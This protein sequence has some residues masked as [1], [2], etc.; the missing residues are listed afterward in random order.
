MWLVHKHPSSLG[1]RSCLQKVVYILVIDRFEC[2]K[3]DIGTVVTRAVYV[4]CGVRMR[5]I[6]SLLHDVM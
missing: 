5:L 1:K 4:A 3:P 2:H 6:T